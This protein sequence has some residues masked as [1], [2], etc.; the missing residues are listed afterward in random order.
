MEGLEVPNQPK[1]RLTT[2]WSYISLEN[3]EN[4]TPPVEFSLEESF[5]PQN[6]IHVLQESINTD[7]FKNGYDLNYW[8]PI[9]LSVGY[10]PTVVLP[11]DE[12]NDNG[13]FTNQTLLLN[14]QPKAFGLGRRLGSDLVDDSHMEIAERMLPMLSNERFLHEHFWIDI[15]KALY[16]CDEGGDN[17]LLSWISHS[18]RSLNLSGAE[19]PTYMKSMGTIEDTCRSLYYTFTNSP[20]TV[21]TLAWY[22]REDSQNDYA[23]WHLEW[24]MASME[25]ALSGYHTDVA[26]ALNRVYWLEY[27]YCPIG[28]GKWFHFKNHRW[29]EVNQGIELRKAM[30]KEFMKRFEQVRSVLSAQIH[31]SN[32]ESFRS[33]GEI[34]VKKIGTLIGKLK[35]VSFKSNILIESCEHF[36]QDR[37]IGLLDTNSEITGLT[38]GVLEIIGAHVQHRHAKPEDYISMSTNNIYQNNLTWECTIVKD[39]M[40]W[41]S[42]VFTEKTLLH[43]FIKFSSS[44]LRGRNADKI[45]P[46]WTGDGDN[47]KSMIVKLF[48]ATLSSYCIKFPVALLSEKA[49]NASGPTP[50]LA[51]A[52]STR[53]AFLDEPEDDVPMHKGTIKRYTG[54]DSFFAR[55][56]QDNGGDVQATFKMVLMC[57][58]VPLIPNAD[59]AIKNRTRL[60][61]FTSTWV[62]DAPLSD[63]EQFR[64]RRF[65]KDP[66]FERK[67]TFL[68]PA[69]LWIMVQYFPYYAAEGLNDPSIITEYTEAYWRDNDIYAQFVGDCIQEVYND[70]TGRRDETARLT[71]TEIYAE[72]KVWFRDAFPGTKPPERTIVRTELSSRWGRIQGN[73]W[74]GLRLMTNDSTSNMTASLGGRPKSAIDVPKISAPV[75]TIENKTLNNKPGTVHPV[76]DKSILTKDIDNKPASLIIPL[77]KTEINI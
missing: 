20:I 28:K 8:L 31:E 73:A 40:K 54:G 51:R 38:N 14:N 60:F 35:T 49:V 6:H 22:A 36:N 27:I 52:K 3:L 62:D 46:I 74:H 61:P 55:L 47:S 32:D 23:Q 10:W 53:L 58:K 34:T 29:S 13:R 50:Q 19:M 7:I 30:S 69:F 21:K 72:F 39:T 26:I 45:F 41:L 57:N 16:H 59:K 71:L 68:A 56:L 43:H 5:E 12:V 77:L 44:C 9:F 65:K 33:I 18:Q 1:L 70:S 63:E 67:I 4:N 17:G 37:F 15:G 75:A 2:I 66:T 64:Q 24:C 76:P 25:Q 48:E 42:Q 11:K